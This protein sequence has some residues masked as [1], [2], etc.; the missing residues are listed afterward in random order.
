MSSIVKCARA[1]LVAAAVALLATPAGAHSHKLKSLEIVHPWCIE[2]HDAA[3]PVA[4]YMTIRNSAGR[5]DRL[6]GATA[7]I[8]RKAELRREAETPA[9]EGDAAASIDVG[10][11]GAVDLKRDGPHIRL[12]GMNKTLGAYDSFFMTLTFRRAG[13]VEVEVMVEE[14]SIL[15]PAK[16]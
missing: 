4:V 8:A 2:T 5:A 9:R 13:K 6:V 10:P 14:A 3:Q 1:L 15:A 16:K 12:T 7:T 11:H